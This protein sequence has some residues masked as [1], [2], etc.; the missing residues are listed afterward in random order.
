V[1]LGPIELLM[2]R[3][4]GTQVGGDVVP[5]LQELV[6]QGTVRLVDLLF[7]TKDDAGNVRLF[8]LDEL[9]PDIAGRFEPLANDITSLLNEEDA[10][11]LAA[12]LERNSSA[13]IML[14]ENTWA[15]R[16]AQA[17]RDAQ[18]EVLLNERI[19]HQVIVEVL[20]ADAIA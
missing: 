6:E 14:F 3:F 9:E 13:G 19:P 2:I 1:N 5:A 15:T 17:V 16:F 18:G 11:E 20:A 7:I 4:P 10:Y 8:E 12:S